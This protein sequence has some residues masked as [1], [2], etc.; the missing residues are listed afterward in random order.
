MCNLRRRIE[1][2]TKIKFMR[3]ASP[4][5]LSLTAISAAAAAAAA[6]RGRKGIRRKYDYPDA[7]VRAG[8]DD[9]TLE[10]SMTKLKKSFSC[11]VFRLLGL[12]HTKKMFSFTRMNENEHWNF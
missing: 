11:G 10:K 2:S 3:M 1:L 7:R 9:D 8:G 5:S 4:N 6:A 12:N